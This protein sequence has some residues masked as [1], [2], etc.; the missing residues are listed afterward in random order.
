MG[1]VITEEAVSGAPRI[2][3]YLRLPDEIVTGRF[4]ATGEPSQD[5]N[6]F[7]SVKDTA[8]IWGA[9]STML[10]PGQRADMHFNNAPG[11]FLVGVSFTEWNP[12][13]NEPT[14]GSGLM[15][16]ISAERGE[17]DIRVVGRNDTGADVFAAVGVVVADDASYKEA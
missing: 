2:V 9:F 8:F 13:L 7:I 15:T 1:R 5:G 6:L 10:S 12:E 3:E 11:T 14:M 17:G 16:L 4:D